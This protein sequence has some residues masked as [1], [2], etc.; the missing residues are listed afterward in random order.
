VLAQEN[1]ANAPFAFPSGVVF[2]LQLNEGGSVF[3]PDGSAIYAAFNVALSARPNRAS[4]N[5]SS[6][7]RTIC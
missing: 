6:M 5:C 3:A 1:A 7:I 2:N 4:R